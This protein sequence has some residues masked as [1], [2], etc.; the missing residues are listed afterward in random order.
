MWNGYNKW[1]LYV[2]ASLHN[3]H[4]SYLS[5]SFSHWFL[6]LDSVDVR[7]A[8]KMKEI[9][10]KQDQKTILLFILLPATLVEHRKCSM[11]E[12][13]YCFSKCISRCAQKSCC[14]HIC[15]MRRQ[16]FIRWKY[17]STDWKINND[18][19]NNGWFDS[20][21]SDYEKSPLIPFL[22]NSNRW[23]VVL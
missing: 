13:F 21:A 16:S 7:K 17:K 4:A 6:C 1:V 20:L 14:I 18:V 15:D 9:L 5:S 10:C 2:I 12:S 8:N 3:A 23:C 19:E 22:D 11:R